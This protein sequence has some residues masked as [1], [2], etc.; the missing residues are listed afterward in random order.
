MTSCE[1]YFNRIGDSQ[2]ISHLFSFLVENI[3]FWGRL[4]KNCDNADG[5][6]E[7]G[8]AGSIFT[9]KLVCKE[10]LRI[11]YSEV[12]E[13]HISNF[14]LYSRGRFMLQQFPK[15]KVVKFYFHDPTSFLPL[16]DSETNEKLPYLDSLFTPSTDIADVSA[17]ENL[18]ESDSNENKSRLDILSNNS[19][20]L[21]LIICNDFTGKNGEPLNRVCTDICNHCGSDKSNFRLPFGLHHIDFVD[22]SGNE[23]LMDSHL[24]TFLNSMPCPIH[25]LLLTR[26]SNV[27]HLFNLFIDK[28]DTLICNQKVNVDGCWRLNDNDLMTVFPVCA[29]DIDE[30]LSVGQILEV[31]ILEDGP[32]EGQWVA[33]EILRACNNSTTASLQ[34]SLGEMLG[35]RYDILVLPTEKFDNAVGF[36]NSP[37]FGIKRKYLRLIL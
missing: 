11:C 9:L 13:L 23:L 27:T 16:I 19:K 3:H 22:F 33:C 30:P 36:S 4:H 12:E 26:C 15:L 34:K 31:V 24:Q 10:W 17:V 5:V 37:A 29:I 14:S 28:P 1:S 18:D 8:P 25:T 2:L 21:Q 35:V 7:Q 32:H 6:H 20:S